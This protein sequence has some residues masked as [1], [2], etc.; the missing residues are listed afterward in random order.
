[1][2]GLRVGDLP[3]NHIID[4]AFE[5]PTHFVSGRADTKPDR[6]SAIAFIL[7]RGSGELCLSIPLA[8]SMRECMQDAAIFA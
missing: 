5:T 3:H 6:A 2:T 1:M 8:R 4:S 7:K